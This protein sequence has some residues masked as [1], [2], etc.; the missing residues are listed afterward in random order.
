MRNKLNSMKSKYLIILLSVFAISL[1]SNEAYA[2]R[3]KSKKRSN[4]SVDKAFDKD[5]NLMDRLWFG[6]MVSPGF[7]GNNSIN[8]FAFGISPMV[9]YKITDK[10]S[11]GPRISATYRH[12]RGNGYDGF[13]FTG[14]QRGNTLSTSYG[15]FGRYKI[16]PAIFAHVEYEAS[17]ANYNPVYQDLTIVGVQYYLAVN[18]VTNEVLVERETRENAYVGLGYSSV[19]GILNTEFSVLYNVLDNSESISIPIVFRFG[20][21]YNF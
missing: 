18:A 3:G 16:L 12:L 2:Q 8:E 9:G 4:S 13:A 7:S 14:P 19:G 10:L 21:N 15:L 5:G 17:I 11:I 20:L 6:G 1:C